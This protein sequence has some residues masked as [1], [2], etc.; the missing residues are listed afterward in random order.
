MRASLMRR[1][2]RL[3]AAERG[4]AVQRILLMPITELA[5]LT[6]MQAT[7]AEVQAFEQ[8]LQQCSDAELHVLLVQYEQRCGQEGVSEDAPEGGGSKVPG[9]SL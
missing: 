8:R 3:E 5:S 1:V 4:S 6:L 9:S 2:A 7:D